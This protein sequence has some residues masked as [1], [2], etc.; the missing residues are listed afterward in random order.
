MFC[1]KAGMTKCGESK[2]VKNVVTLTGKD[3][4]AN[5]YAVNFDKDEG[6][7]WV[8]DGAENTTIRETYYLKIISVTDK[9]LHFE[10]AGQPYMNSYG[11][12]N[13]HMNWGWGGISD[14]WFSE[15]NGFCNVEY[16]LNRKDLIH[17]RPNN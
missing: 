6:H 4:S 3:G 8:C 15:N 2:I 14:G 11:T 13:L 7:A 5:M 1:G 17:I 12:M 10:T 9:P 16:S